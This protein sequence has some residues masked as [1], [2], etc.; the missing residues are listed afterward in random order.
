LGVEEHYNIEHKNEKE[1]L[2]E[3]LKRLRLI[4][5][6]KSIKKEHKNKMQ[7]WDHWQYH[8]YDTALQLST[9]I[10]KKYKNW[11]EN[12]KNHNHPWTSPRGR[13]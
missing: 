3:Y 2:K 10:K 12:K 6:I 5:N 9:G 8:Y 11:I 7:Q 1:K 4:L 13:Y